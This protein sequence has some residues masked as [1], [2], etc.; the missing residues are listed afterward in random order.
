[1]KCGHPDG[2]ETGRPARAMGLCTTHYCRLKRMGDIGPAGRLTMPRGDV[3]LHP[4]GCETGRPVVARGF[5]STHW[6]RWRKSGDIGSAGYLIARKGSSSCAYP[7]GCEVDNPPRYISGWCSVHYDRLDDTGV[8]GPPGKMRAGNNEATACNHPDGCEL[9]GRIIKGYCQ[10]HFTRLRDSGNLG[11]SGLLINRDGCRHPDGCTIEHA[12]PM[13]EYCEVHA[14][15]IKRGSDIGPP[16]LM[17]THE[18]LTDIETWVYVLSDVAERVLYVGLSAS[19]SRRFDEH[20]TTKIWWNEVKEIRH[21]WF[22]D[23][24]SAIDAERMLIKTHTPAYNHTHNRVSA[25]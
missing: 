16:G 15:R 3:C 7:D 25:I 8:L 20:R 9:T 18:H 24:L 13:G 6:G 5:C 22:P 14:A 4:D 2:C 10:T 21:I 23:R 17:S 12:R 1:M 19:P 11:P